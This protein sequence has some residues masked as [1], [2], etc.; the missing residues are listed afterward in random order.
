MALIQRIIVGLTL[1]SMVG[2][3]LADTAQNATVFSI[4][5]RNMLLLFVSELTEAKNIHFTV[6][7]PTSSL[8]PTGDICQPG[9]EWHTYKRI[10]T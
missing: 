2:V 3:C 5:V 6:W 7:I 4:I 9:D 1:L 8:R 10:Q